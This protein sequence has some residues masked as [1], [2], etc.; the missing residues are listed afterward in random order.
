MFSYKGWRLLHGGQRID[1]LKPKNLDLDQNSPKSPDPD[2]INMDPQQWDFTRVF[3]LFI[4]NV[5]LLDACML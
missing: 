1:F 4:N 2:S 3:L 5:D